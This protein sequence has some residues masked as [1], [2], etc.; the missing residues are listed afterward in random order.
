MFLFLHILQGSR[1][2]LYYCCDCEAVHDSCVVEYFECRLDFKFEYT[3]EPCIFNF[4]ACTR[5][6][7]DRHRYIHHGTMSSR[8]R[9]R[10]L[11]H[12]K[13]DDNPK[14]P[15]NLPST[16]ALS[17]QSRVYGGKVRFLFVII[18]LT[19]LRNRVNVLQ[20]TL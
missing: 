15:H 3:A 20:R 19:S 12:S 8:Y 6:A 11:K 10:K 1:R 13:L 7:V 16:S 4:G 9:S 5:E 14:R 18:C 17:K 2:R